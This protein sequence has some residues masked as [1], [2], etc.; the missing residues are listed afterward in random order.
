MGPTPQ[1]D[2]E[3]ALADWR[4][5]QDAYKEAGRRQKG[6]WEMPYPSITFKQ[7]DTEIELSLQRSRPRSDYAPSIQPE[8]DVQ[9][10]ATI[11]RRF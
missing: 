11:R 9:A 3:K 4:A 2:M 6:S 5:Q 1:T 10:R 8:G 7:N